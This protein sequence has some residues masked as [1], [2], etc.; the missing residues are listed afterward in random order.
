MIEQQ[1]ET[2]EDHFTQIPNA[3]DNRMS[4]SHATQINSSS[5]ASRSQSRHSF[6]DDT[7]VS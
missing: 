4:F 2:I 6:S 1:I 5:H 3:E 7:Q